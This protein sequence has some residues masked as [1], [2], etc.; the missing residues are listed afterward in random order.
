MLFW[1]K[2]PDALAFI[3]IQTRLYLWCFFPVGRFPADYRLDKGPHYGIHYYYHWLFNGND[4][5]AGNEPLLSRCVIGK[6]K[7]AGICTS[8]ADS[9]QLILPFIFN[10]FHILSQ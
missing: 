2:I 3:F 9:G 8:M 7:I 6:K 5:F 10:L 1:A 4:H